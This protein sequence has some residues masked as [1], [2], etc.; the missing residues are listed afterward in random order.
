[1]AEETSGEQDSQ[2]LREFSDRFVSAI[3]LWKIMALVE[4]VC[5]DLSMYFIFYD[6]VNVLVFLNK[7]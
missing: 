3:L 2:T 1:M 7:R 4:A 5:S 6:F